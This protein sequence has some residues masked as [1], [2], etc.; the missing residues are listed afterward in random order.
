MSNIITHAGPYRVSSCADGSIRI[1]PQW[2]GIPVYNDNDGG[3]PSMGDRMELARELEL[4]LNAVC[5]GEKA[6]ARYLLS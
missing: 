4:H 5:D 6:N 1:Y 2:P 3:G